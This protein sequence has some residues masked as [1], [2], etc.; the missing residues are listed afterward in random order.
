MHATHNR[1]MNRWFHVYADKIAAGALVLGCAVYLFARPASL[2]YVGGDLSAPLIGQLPAFS[3]T[4]A[5]ALA[6]SL[7]V[8]R[9]TQATTVI[10]LWGAV[11]AL[12][13][14]AQHE[15]V[16]VPSV[17]DWYQQASTFDLLDL[18][19]IL[20]AVIVAVFINHTTRCR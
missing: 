5:F 15:A 16:P 9:K 19:A 12:A 8:R 10:L 4:L 1:P 6:S 13:E 11:E 14:I 7:V 17:F 18:A 20:A 2:F 3:H